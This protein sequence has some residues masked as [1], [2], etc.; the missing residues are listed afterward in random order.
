MK[1]IL[2]IIGPESS[3]T[4]VFMNL[5]SKHE[6][7]VGNTS[8]NSHV[9]VLDD[10]WHY[11]EQRKIIS[12]K[13]KLPDIAKNQFYVT[14]RSMPHASSPGIS[15]GYM[16]FP[17]LADFLRYCKKSDLN[18]IVLITNRSPIANLF[19]WSQNRASSNGDIEKS[20]QQYKESYIQIFKSVTKYNVPYLMLSMEALL[21]D[22]QD[23]INSIFKLCDI[24]TTEFDDDINF[25]VNMKHYKLFLREKSGIEFAL[26]EFKE[27]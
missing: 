27:E 1:K 18:P 10:I 11:L 25:D 17:P 20:Y 22:K 16:Q 3:G 21:V 23:Y 24:P 13:P 26:P 12:A 5:F 9:D 14:R 7:A 15:A 19:S 4:R 6:K 8:P 2:I